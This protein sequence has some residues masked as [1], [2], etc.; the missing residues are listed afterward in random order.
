MK[1]IHLINLIFI[2]SSFCLLS[3]FSSK[4]A[5]K[6][7]SKYFEG[8]IVYAITYEPYSDRFDAEELEYS[9]GSKMELTF[10]HGNYKR[11]YFS[12]DGDLISERM[13][14]LQ[15]EKSYSKSRGN[16]TLYWFD[17]TKNDT[18]TDFIQT[19][20]SLILDHP[21]IGIKAKSIV[22]GV[23][24]GDKTYETSGF[25]HFAKNMKIN[26]SWYSNYKEGNFNEM[27][28]IT[29]GIQLLMLDHG[30]FWDQKIVATSIEHR[31]IDENEIKLD[32][33]KYKILKEL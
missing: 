23:G 6:T 29:K 32:L 5:N 2:L 15:A 27:V 13:L 22:S 19:N 7:K 3:C 17:I 24:F 26:P 21:T 1:N 9:I 10:K 16:D 25:Y 30:L 14:D 12:P 4:K 11:Q 28:K 20:D 8:V 33:S 18:K 31:I